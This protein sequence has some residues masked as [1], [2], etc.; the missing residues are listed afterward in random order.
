[1]Q[2]DVQRFHVEVDRID[3]VLFA[4]V[5]IMFSLLLVVLIL[6]SLCLVKGVLVIEQSLNQLVNAVLLRKS[7]LY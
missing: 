7:E 1:M 6:Q 3:Q 4:F 2:I 5:I